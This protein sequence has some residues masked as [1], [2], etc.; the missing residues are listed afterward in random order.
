MKVTLMY[1]PINKGELIDTS[2]R[3]AVH[4]NEYI[5]QTSISNSEGIPVKEIFKEEI[6]LNKAIE[7]DITKARGNPVFDELLDALISK[8]NNRK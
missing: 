2:F 7:L 8:F 5:I 4:D 1:L 3:L 6:L